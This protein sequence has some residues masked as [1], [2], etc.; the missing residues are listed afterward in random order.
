ASHLGTIA[1]GQCMYHSQAGGE[2][3]YFIWTS[4]QVSEQELARSV[5][6]A[7]YD[8]IKYYDYNRPQLQLPAAHFTNLVWTSVEKMGVGLYTGLY[9]NSHGA[10]NVVASKVRPATGY[11]VVVHESPAGNIM[12]TEEFERNV[13]RPN[14]A[15]SF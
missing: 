7:F 5:M 9:T 15:F 8:E 12:T 11:M 2:N 1:N 13:G 14:R 3:I 10:C 6:K 4:C